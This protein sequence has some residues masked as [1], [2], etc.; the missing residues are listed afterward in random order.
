M[1][2]SPKPP[3]DQAL[4]RWN[5]RPAALTPKQARAAVTSS[6][7]IR[8]QRAVTRSPLLA[9]LQAALLIGSLSITCLALFWISHRNSGPVSGPESPRQQ[10]VVTKP[11]SMPSPTKPTLVV[12][13]LSS[14]TQL[15]HSLH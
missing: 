4:N 7:P 2:R 10:P 3:F 6:L 1:N 12:V 5:S 14:G 8:P 9:A 13:N 15:Y 11:L